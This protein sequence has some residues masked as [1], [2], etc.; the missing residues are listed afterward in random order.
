MEGGGVSVRIFH[1]DCREILPTLP[2]DSV[3]CCVSS[4]PYWGQRD[5]GISGQI[6]LESSPEEYCASLVSMF[7]EVRRALRSDGTLWL[8]LGDRWASD[9][10][11]SYKDKDLVGVPWMVAF[12]LRA[13]GWY[14]RQ[15]NIWAKSNAMPESVRDRSTASHE[16]VFHLSK[17][18]N[19]WYDAEAARTPAMPSTETRLSQEVAG[20]NGSK[21]AN[22]GDDP[23]PMKAGGRRS[24]KQRGHTRRHAGFNARWDAMPIEER[25]ANSANLRSVWWIAPAKYREG[26]FAVMPDRLA[27]ICIAAGCPIGGVVLDPFLGAGT[28]AL[29]ADRMQRDCI[30]I[31]LNPKYIE[32]GERRIKGESPLFAE[33]NL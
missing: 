2:A 22:G 7:R 12:A 23:R 9:G 32:M 14:L 4:P 21:R 13:D 30:G 33:V 27:E 8:N 6:G 16:Y 3:H 15:C 26:H 1:G 24:D 10:L 17:N 31:E 20:Q 19:Y 29:V 5:Y 18:N 11:S 25:R 28:T